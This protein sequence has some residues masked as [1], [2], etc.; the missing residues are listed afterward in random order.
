[1]K[2]CL[3]N[4]ESKELIQFLNPP[5]PQD[6]QNGDM[7]GPH[8]CYWDTADAV[9]FFIVDDENH[10]F[11]Y[12]V[13]EGIFNMHSDTKHTSWDSETQSWVT[14]RPSLLDNIRV[15]RNMLL[16][17]TDWTQVTD[18]P[19]SSEKKQEFVTYRQAL[20]DMPSTY[21]NVGAPGDVVWPTPPS[22]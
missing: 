2:L 11:V 14:D 8:Q 3:V 4:P 1:M 10:R 6:Y 12:D 9:P 7:V 19:F 21:E 15:D 13:V 5:N 22:L 17:N 16:K 20:R 18:A